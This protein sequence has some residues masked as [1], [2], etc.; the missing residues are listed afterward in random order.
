MK[1]HTALRK[2][3]KVG[4]FALLGLALLVS[5]SCKSATE[6][7]VLANIIA[8]NLSGA[9][10]DIFRDGV[11][12]FSVEH[13]TD[14]TI[15]DL[16]L[17]TYNLQAKKKG[18][19]IQVTSDTLEVTQSSNY[20]WV[21]EGPSYIVIENKYGVSLDIY[22]N[23]TYVGPVPKDE[24]RVITKVA[25]GSHELAAARSQDGLVVEQLTLEVNDVAEYI[26]T[27]EPPATR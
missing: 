15:R 13:A 7:E 8:Q 12:Q 10:L 27:I 17:G 20:V 22:M 4:T 18:E 21:I 1:K 24:G 23:G 16:P 25:F 6:P 2:I 9:A 3:G 11:Y 26:W 5:F 14:E 19:D